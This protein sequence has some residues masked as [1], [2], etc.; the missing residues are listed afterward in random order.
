MMTNEIDPD[1]I[2]RAW[3]GRISGCQLGKPVE[4]LSMTQGRQPLLD[5][6]KEA[7]ALPLRDYVPL[8]EDTMVARFGRHSC[9]NQISRS[10]PDDDINYSALALIMLEQHGALAAR[11]N[12]AASQTVALQLT[13]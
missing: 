13:K 10:E 12:G 4:L 1:R 5:Y 8:I 7:G 11:D 2:R 6:L 3:Q 9:L